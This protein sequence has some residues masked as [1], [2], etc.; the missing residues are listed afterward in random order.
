MKRIYI[1]LTAILLI[2][3]GFSCGFN[4]HGII[5]G[6]IFS[7][8]LKPVI[9]ADSDYAP[10]IFWKSML[11]VPIIEAAEPIDEPEPAPTVDLSKPK[12]MIYCTHSA[13][14]YR[15][16]FGVDKTEGVNAGIFEV[17]TT[18]YNSLIE[19][20]IS[21]VLCNTVHD[22]PDWSKSYANSLA[23]IQTM[24]E[25]YPSLE[26]FIDVHRDAP[27]NPIKNAIKTDTAE[28]AK[29]ML[30][31]GSESRIAHPTWEQNHSFAKKIGEG[32]EAGVRGVLRGV[33]VQNGRY[34]QHI[35]TKSILVEMGTNLNTLTQAQ[36]TA[37][38]LAS[39]LAD[40]LTEK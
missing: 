4:A 5:L 26:V 3:V 33:K 23:S 39:V 29:I 12:V 15:P 9:V 7:L 28:Y 38:L 21:A 24:K 17:A 32:L 22:F 31:V 36:N 11:S 2:I 27:A 1:L 10:S 16:T 34:N 6:D 25:Q 19:Q 8:G 20:G 37:K 35:S 40:L 30:V 13:E 18:L 14:S